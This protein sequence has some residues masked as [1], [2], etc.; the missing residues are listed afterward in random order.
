MS[1]RMNEVGVVDAK[2]GEVHFEKRELPTDWPLPD[3]LVINIEATGLCGTDLLVI[4][5]AIGSEAA[6]FPLTPCHEG[7]GTVCGI[8][9]NVVEGSFVIGQRVGVPW[10]QSTCGSCEPCE[11]GKDYLC[12]SQ[13][14]SGFTACGTLSSFVSVP[15]K[16][17]VKIPDV[18]SAEA[19]AP[20]LCAGLTS[21]KSVEAC[22]VRGGDWV[23]IIG[24]A[25][26][27][28]HLGVQFAKAEGMK[29]IALE[30][31]TEKC[32]FALSV[33]ADVAIL[34]SSLDPDSIKK[35]VTDVCKASD[36][37]GC[38]AV[39]NYAPSVPL[40]ECSPRLARVGGTIVIVSL[41]RSSRASIDVHD[42]VFHGKRLVGSIVG[43]KRDAERALDF[44]ARGLV[45]CVT[46][47]QPFDSANM[48]IQNL[49]NGEYEGRCVLSRT[50][51]GVV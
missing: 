1:K 7:V 43:T 19:A 37:L 33:G 16:H 2:G 5:A 25:G 20:F 15:A 21:F 4:D 17:V 50:T 36:G 8:G 13:L 34:S 47:V 24:A 10:L 32:D 45:E 29:V 42:L 22:D 38:H 35:L 14:N 3:D 46:H 26:G 49:R 23:C 6:N 31:T 11:T 12:S 39:I 9:K 41:P 18:L 51:T 30:S 27:L 48:M 40:I 28:G 44:A